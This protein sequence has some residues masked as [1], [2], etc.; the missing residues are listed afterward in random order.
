MKF[1]SAA[2]GVRT[3]GVAAVA[4]LLALSTPAR[5]QFGGHRPQAPWGRAWGSTGTPL[6]HP[7]Q[8]HPVTGTVSVARLRHN[9][10]SR[11]LR[12]FE[13][14]Q[15]AEHKG[16]GQAA[17]AHFKNATEIDP[18]F[19][20][21]CNNLGVGHLR[22]HQFEQAI[23][24]FQWA[25]SLDGSATLVYANLGTAY[26]QTGRFPDAERTARQ[27]LKHDSSSNR[28]RLVLGIALDAQRRDP[29]EALENLAAAAREFPQARL[30]AAH[31]LARDGE[32]S[33]AAVELKKYLRSGS[34]GDQRQVE[35]WLANLEQ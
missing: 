11:A 24:Q 12:E 18:G 14:A 29:R 16:D 35:V 34:G 33:R 13:K 30:V 1:L 6:I 17:M 22:L 23:A 21:A 3:A 8:E 28:L 20:E 32:P 15:A 2:R 10:P 4:L 5:A 25:L 31:I 7:R 19:F 26:F 27:G 9:V